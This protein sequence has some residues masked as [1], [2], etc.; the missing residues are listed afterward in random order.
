MKELDQISEN[1]LAIIQNEDIRNF[2]GDAI[3]NLVQAL[4]SGD[5]FTGLSSIK[6]F[7]DMLFHAPTVIF[8]NKMQ[9]FLLGTFKNFDEQIKMSSQFSKDNKK[10]K[11][12][13]M[14]L[15]ETIDKLDDEIK[16]DYYSTLTRSFLL[17]L[18]DSD[19]FFK[20]RQI[21]INCTV[22]ELEFI[23]EHKD[24]EHFEYNMMIF[25]LKN[26]GL[27]HQIVE[28]KTYYVFTDLAKSLKEYAL[29]ENENAKHKTTYFELEA[30]KDLGMITKENIDDMFK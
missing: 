6:N 11:K 19:L 7:K 26:Y 15:L 16:V 10:Y 1:F 29:T 5:V 22:S 30:P 27:I 4:Y 23:S 20:L 3:W 28:N 17:E 24:N 2:S 12:F 18:I 9:R 21:L 13:V 14:Q 25:A 8:W